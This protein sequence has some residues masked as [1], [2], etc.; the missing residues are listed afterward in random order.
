MMVCSNAC[1]L[2]PL[3]LPFEARFVGD[4]PTHAIEIEARPP[5]FLPRN[6]RALSA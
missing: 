1:G 4:A 6:E 2:L 3:A 5:A